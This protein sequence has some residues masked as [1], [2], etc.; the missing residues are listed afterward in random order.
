MYDGN[1]ARDAEEFD[2]SRGFLHRSHNQPRQVKSRG[3]SDPPLAIIFAGCED[4]QTSADVKDPS[5]PGMAFGGAMCS[6]VDRPT[7]PFAALTKTFLDVL[8]KNNSITFEGIISQV[9]G[10]L[11]NQ[12]F[13]QVPWLG[14]LT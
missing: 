9:R 10:I 7:Y 13:Q 3:L 4:N 2:L 11:K 1:C 5:A 6:L 8:E 12:K 14:F